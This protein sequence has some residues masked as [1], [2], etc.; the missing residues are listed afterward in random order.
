M[1]KKSRTDP[2]TK[3]PRTEHHSFGDQNPF[4][5]GDLAAWL[6]ANHPWPFLRS[7][8][9]QYL[10]IHLSGVII[11]SDLGGILYTYE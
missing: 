3:T 8:G 5:A 7:F 1:V 9:S 11:C 4:E 10:Y 6:S 2:N